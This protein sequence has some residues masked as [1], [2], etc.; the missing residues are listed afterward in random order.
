MSVFYGTARSFT[1]G[2]YNASQTGITFLRMF[3]AGLPNIPEGV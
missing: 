1:K 2:D 3:E